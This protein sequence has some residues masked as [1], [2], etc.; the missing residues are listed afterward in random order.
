MLEER[1]RNTQIALGILEIDRIHFV[2]HCRRADLTGLRFLREPAV[3]DVAPDI[4]RKVDE[5]RVDA[6]QVVEKFGVGIVR[7]YL[8]CCRIQFEFDRLFLIIESSDELFAEV[9]PIHVRC[10]RHM[11]TPIPGRP[12]A[13]HENGATRE[14][15]KLASYP[16][17]EHTH[18]LAE[19]RRTRALSVR[20]REHRC[21][22]LF[23]RHFFEMCAHVFERGY[24][25]FLERTAEE[26]GVGDVVGVFRCEREMHPFGHVDKRRFGKFAFEKILNGFYVVIRRRYPFVPF[27]LYLLDDA[28]VLE[29]DL[30]E[31]AQYLFLIRSEG[32]D[33]DVR[34][35]R[36]RD[37]VFAFDERA[38]A[39]E[40]ELAEIFRERRGRVAVSTVYGNYRGERFK[41]HIV[42]GCVP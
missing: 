26:K 37:E 42:S 16:R 38:R 21:S 10:A 36:K 39:D 18:L 27:F 6:A 2:R 32:A 4:L 20:A 34:C 40:R 23:F 24:Y 29:S 41:W 19:G 15:F 3:A 33:T 28:C 17:L 11:R 1:I 30:G 31:L 8:R 35:F 12:A 13:F 5:Y 14:L 9:H 25:H 7:F 22:R